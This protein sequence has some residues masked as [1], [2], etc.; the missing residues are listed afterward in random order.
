MGIVRNP[1]RIAFDICETYIAMKR[2][3]TSGS[4]DFFKYKGKVNINTESFRARKDKSFFYIL[5]KQLKD[6]EKIHNFILANIIVYGKNIYVSNL[7]TVDA[8]NNYKTFIVEKESIDYN[9][10]LQIKKLFNFLEL[11][12]LSFTEDLF[13][14]KEGESPLIITLYYQNFISLFTLMVIDNITNCLLTFNSKPSDIILKDRY[15]FLIKIKP[16]FKKD[17][18]KIKFKRIFKDN[19]LLYNS[20]LNN[21][22]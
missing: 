13:K 16:F 21:V 11:N 22:V 12:R 6:Q 3:F 19:L 14:I 10:E 4:Y 20:L 9:F 2:H 5:A 1:E 15:E 18:S 7:V 8:I 17:A